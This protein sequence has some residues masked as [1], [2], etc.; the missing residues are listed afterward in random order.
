V[1][2]TVTTVQKKK[3]ER[4]PIA[5]VIRKR[6]GRVSRTKKKAGKMLST[7]ERVKSGRGSGAQK[8]T[9]VA[10]LVLWGRGFSKGKLK[11]TTGLNLNKGV[12]KR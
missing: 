1:V 4:V 10:D 8:R 3:G 6:G 9:D 5:E 11:I 7:D 12:K 2:S